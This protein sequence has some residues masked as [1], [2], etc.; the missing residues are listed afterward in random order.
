MNTTLIHQN[1]ENFSLRNVLMNTLMWSCL[2]EILDL[3]TPDTMQ[4]PLMEDQQVIEALSPDTLQKASLQGILTERA[5][6]SSLQKR[7]EFYNTTMG[8]TDKRER[9]E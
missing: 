3:S 6:K 7:P 1:G 5:N 9:K 8:K 4:L 2:I